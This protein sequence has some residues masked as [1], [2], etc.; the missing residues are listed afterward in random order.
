MVKWISMITQQEA[1]E[2]SKAMSREFSTNLLLPEERF[3]S[4]LWRES[5]R[6]ER[7]GKNLLLVLVDHGKGCERPTKCRSLTQ[8]AGALRSVIRDTDIA[9]WFDPNCVLGVIFS[10]FGHSDVNLAAQA[11][12]AKITRSLQ[13]ALTVQQLSRVHISLF[14]FPDN[15]SYSRK[16]ANEMRYPSMDLH[17][18]GNDLLAA[19]NS[20]LHF[21]GT[22]AE[23]SAGRGMRF[24]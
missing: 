6:S 1:T 7:S 17:T 23:L 24:D 19:C 8:A 2:H 9:G 21:R 14:A 16:T 11:I 20:I 12:E 15:E 5:K 13:R 18:K 4:M 10:E 3:Q 22:V